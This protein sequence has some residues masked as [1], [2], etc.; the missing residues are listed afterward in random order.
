VQPD[1]TVRTAARQPG[2]D[3]WL[4]VVEPA[5]GDDREPACEAADRFLVGEGD[6]GSAQPGAAVHP[7]LGVF[8]DQDVGG[9]GIAQERFEDAGAEEL[10]V[11][12]AKRVE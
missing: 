4:G 6:L 9:V 11:Q 1:S 10:L 5:T 7:D 8:V 2:I 12:H 3:M